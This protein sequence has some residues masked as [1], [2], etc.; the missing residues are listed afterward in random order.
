MKKYIAFAAVFLLL[1]LPLFAGVSAIEKAQIKDE[2]TFDGKSLAQYSQT[3]G[4][5]EIDGYSAYLINLDTGTL[6]YEIR[7]IPPQRQS[8]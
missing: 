7:Y 2:F 1:G 3:E 6:V 5:P 4:V 8:L